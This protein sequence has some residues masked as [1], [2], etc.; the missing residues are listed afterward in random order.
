LLKRFL[1]INGDSLRYFNR[2]ALIEHTE[3]N[4]AKQLEYYQKVF[5]TDSS[6]SNIHLS[7]G[8][9]Y[10]LN[11]QFD[12]AKYHFDKWIDSEN[13]NANS[14]I[15]RMHR[16]AYTFWK[17]GDTTKANLYFGKQIENC[18]KA[19]ESND[20]YY[21]K[22]YASY[23]LAGTYAFNGKKDLAYENL[24][25]LLRKQRFDSWLIPLIS[26][27]PLFEPIRNEKRFKDIMD[28]IETSYHAEHERV[29][30][31]LE[32]NDML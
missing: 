32:D 13:Q 3:G 21:A 11:G 25:L 10:M 4:Y 17:T 19:K 8:E 14:A 26:H 24:E 15:N 1:N 2:L 16:I 18:I 23:D 12:Q 27:D 20:Y 7:L 31:W 6:L 9:S 30:Q 5:K 29:R 22:G 28:Y